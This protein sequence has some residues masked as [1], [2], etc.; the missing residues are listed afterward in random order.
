MQTVFPL[1]GGQPFLLPL[2][3]GFARIT[4]TLIFSHNHTVTA[5]ERYRLTLVSYR[6]Y[7][8]VD[9]WW[10]IGAYNGIVNPLTDVLP[11]TVLA[12]PSRSSVDG[13]FRTLR[14]TVGSEYVVLP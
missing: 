11:G 3:P 9:L 14:Q 4:R 2:T 10:V 1:D 13:Y 8:T 12:I 5:D 6:E 7:G